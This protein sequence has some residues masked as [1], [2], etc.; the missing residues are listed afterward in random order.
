MQTK[1]LVLIG[2]MGSGKTTVGRLLSR[3]TGLVFEDL[4]A[5]LEERAGMSIPEIFEKE[6]EK[7]FRDR[8]TALIADL[9]REG[10]AGRVYSCGGG[11]PC[12]EE[13][14]RLLKEMGR[15]IWLDVRAET[16]IERL[17]GDRNRPLLQRPDRE[18]AISRMLADRRGA[19]ESAADLVVCADG[20]TPGAIAREIV[21]SLEDNHYEDTGH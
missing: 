7:G 10:A 15:V 3:K 17:A 8:E 19:Y 9:V 6:T 11:A 13:N 14:R 5:L 18:E 1:N 12:R 2:Y 4:D 16:V 20:K 21:K